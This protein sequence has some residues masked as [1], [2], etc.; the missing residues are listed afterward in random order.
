MTAMIGADFGPRLLQIA[1]CLLGTGAAA[2]R[3][4]PIDHAAGPALRPLHLNSPRPRRRS[5]R[6]VHR[7]RRRRSDFVTTTSSDART[8]GLA[9]RLGFFVFGKATLAGRGSLVDSIAA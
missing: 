9:D 7:P 2:H 4:E 3:V 1:S 5:P 8:A 6:R